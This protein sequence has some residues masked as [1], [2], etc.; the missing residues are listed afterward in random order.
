MWSNVARMELQSNKWG[1]PG[2]VNYFANF[3]KE[4]EYQDGKFPTA[5]I[6]NQEEL[7]IQ[8]KEQ[9]RLDSTKTREEFMQEAQKKK[10]LETVATT[11]PPPEWI[12]SEIEGEGAGASSSVGPRGAPTAERATAPEP[13]PS[14]ERPTLFV[15]E[16]DSYIMSK[17]GS[18]IDF[19]RFR[20]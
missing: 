7:R 5:Q 11:L 6:Y 3:R 2:K 16:G 13:M 9:R 20:R 1:D 12:G 8:R 4:S 14:E 15:D 18:G 17:H 19:A 10:K